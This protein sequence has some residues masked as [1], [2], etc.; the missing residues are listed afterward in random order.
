MIP[1]HAPLPPAPPNPCPNPCPEQNSPTRSSN[2]CCTMHIRRNEYTSIPTRGPLSQVQGRTKERAAIGVCLDTARV[3]R[4][5]VLGVKL[6]VQPRQALPIPQILR[7]IDALCRAVVRAGASGVGADSG[8]HFRDLQRQFSPPRPRLM[9]F[10]HPFQRSYDCLD[11]L[12]HSN[13][14][15]SPRGLRFR[16]LS[17][18]W[19]K[20]QG[21][22]WSEMR[23]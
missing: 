17:L 14:P 11:V 4:H 22:E 12:S 7:R 6:L 13:M 9:R 21:V 3:E 16:S 5:A 18:R 10:L 2:L 1:C 19:T 23:R 8:G 20:E 15:I